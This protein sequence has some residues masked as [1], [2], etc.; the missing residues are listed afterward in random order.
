MQC[1][2][3]NKIRDNND[4]IIMY[5]FRDGKGNEFRLDAEATKAN[6]MNGSI[7][8]TNLKLT[9]NGRIISC[10]VEVENTHEELSARLRRYLVN[11]STNCNIAFKRFYDMDTVVS[12]ARMLGK[13]VEQF[14]K[15]YVISDNKNI[16]VASEYGIRLPADSFALFQCLVAD[17]VSLSGLNGELVVSLR[18]AFEGC[19]INTLDLSGIYGCQPKDLS[20]MFHSGHVK[21]I[22]FGDFD[23][24]RVSSMSGM[25]E[26]F[27]GDKLCLTGLD[28]RNCQFMD[29]MFEGSS[30]EELDIHINVKGVTDMTRMFFEADIPFIDLSSFSPHVRC[31][32]RCMFGY[33]DAKVRSYD[34]RII[35]RANNRDTEIP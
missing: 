9:S 25:F 23:T 11:I 7:E 21:N 18:K 17:K 29:G 5:Q 19:H 24:S 1:F 8:P 27:E 26:G 32:T 28:T 3:F 6:I 10:K 34:N 30:L 12:K 22:I 35:S 2:C 20:S 4:R 14:R 33:C 31:D 15:I 13:T 16:L